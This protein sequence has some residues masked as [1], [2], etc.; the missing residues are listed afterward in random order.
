[1]QSFENTFWNASETHKDESAS[2]HHPVVETT[3]P[4]TV[5]ATTAD[6]VLLL[7]QPICQPEFP[8]HWC[9]QGLLNAFSE[10]WHQ[11]NKVSIFL[12]VLIEKLPV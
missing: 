11:K 12:N 9:F 10:A 2:S 7:S 5:T 6:T 3:L 8:N 4:E 1:M